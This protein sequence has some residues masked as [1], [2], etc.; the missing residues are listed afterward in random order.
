M[1][2]STSL[3]PDTPINVGISSCLLGQNVR[4]NGGHSQSRLCLDSLSQFFTFSPF[5]PEMAAGFGT[6]RPVMRLIG[7]PADPR[8]VYSDNATQDLTEQ[9]QSGFADKIHNSGE[10]DGYILMKNSPSCGLERIKIYQDNGHPHID[11]GRGLFTEALVARYPL[12]PV[13]EEGRLNDAHLRENFILRVYAHHNFR[14]EVL[15]TPSYHNLLQFHSSYK[16]VLMA[17]SQA[18]YKTLGRLLAEAHQQPLDELLPDYL[19]Q[20]MAALASPARRKGHTNVLMHILGY[21]KKTV[22]GEARQ[23]MV[24]VIHRYREGKIP[25][26]TPLTLLRHYIDREGSDYIRTQ[27]YLQ[28]YPEDL[29]LRN[30]L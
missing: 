28:P 7:D 11:R 25:L 29:G 3:V 24:E 17:H 20:L 21:L 4:Y 27:R 13:E 23:N 16:Y 18:A 1:T 6:P 2:E 8:L 30:Q 10:L 5:C 22:A 12:L 15:A 19:Q 9:L 26:V 14:Q